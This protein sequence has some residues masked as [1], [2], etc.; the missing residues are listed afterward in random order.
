MPLY[1][2]LGV[3]LVPHTQL[4]LAADHLRKFLRLTDPALDF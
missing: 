4:K 2:G 1:E 3:G